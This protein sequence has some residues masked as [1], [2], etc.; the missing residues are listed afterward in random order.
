MNQSVKLDEILHYQDDR[1]FY[2]DCIDW[3]KKRL[4]FEVEKIRCSR[5]EHF[6]E[7]FGGLFVSDE[8]VD[9]FILEYSTH[10]DTGSTNTQ[11]LNS[12]TLIENLRQD[13]QSIL[14]RKSLTRGLKLQR[15][16]GLYELI[17][18]E[19]FILLVSYLIELEPRFQK[20][21]A[22]VQD[23][24]QKKQLTLSLCQRISPYDRAA[25]DWHAVLLHHEPL[26]RAP[27]I[28]LIESDV[29]R[30]QQGIV[31]DDGVRNFLSGCPA[32]DDS[33]AEKVRWVTPKHGA[34]VN[35]ILDDQFLTP[36]TLI[37]S[38][39]H[40]I[41]EWPVVSLLTD[42]VDT[43]LLQLSN[44]MNQSIQR[45]RVTFDCCPIEFRR[46]LRDCWMQNVIPVIECHNA[47]TLIE[48][49]GES[50]GNRTNEPRSAS[51]PEWIKE[52]RN[53]F[54]VC[55][56]LN[57]PRPGCAQL[58]I[59]RPSLTTNEQYLVWQ[60]CLPDAYLGLPEVK[61]VLSTLTQQ[62]QFSVSDIESVATTLAM[63]MTWKNAPE[64]IEH[65]SQLC[66]QKAAAPMVQLAQLVSTQFRWRDLVVNQS[67]DDELRFF[68]R[69]VRYSYQYVEASGMDRILGSAPSV[70]ALFS[71]PSGTGKTMAASVLANELGLDLFKIDLSRVVSKY[72]GE[73]EKNL[74]RIFNAAARSRSILFFDEG[75]ALFGKRSEVK[76]AH[77]RYANIEVSYL[78]QK[79]EEH[80]GCTIIATN[81][82]DNIDDAF[83]RRLD[84]IVSFPL[85]GEVERTRIWQRLKLLSVTVD[86]DIDF[87][88]LAKQFQFTGGHIKNC[89]VS[90]CYAAKEQASSVS[91]LHL[92]QAAV[93]EYRKLKR[94]IKRTLL[95]PYYDELVKGE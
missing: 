46:F 4:G 90:A 55:S 89:L 54:V 82:S 80:R 93:R 43:C 84:H 81:F 77:D 75:D 69:N 25:T 1:A 49:R 66:R 60:N 73:T 52:H 48:C 42:D 62:F 35:N 71:G 18:I 17:P 21:F 9:E 53:G 38:G 24:V 68:H 41:A 20:L 79:I 45:F 5:G 23:D 6:R 14:K 22:Y 85:P 40:E 13:W 83:S 58:V 88:F 29:S 44:Y 95:G 31:C 28:R 19:S 67:V 30:N 50:R 94:P 63:E 72:I 12:K 2:S 32:S 7:G 27:L 33:L 34:P 11:P 26:R 65:L 56:R 87:D 47:S 70:S 59:R 3:L 16:E 10:S 78:L 51:L 91:M 74:D 76:D 36:F 57:D 86:S 39:T 61:D 92:L 15:I 8:E 64:S 37:K